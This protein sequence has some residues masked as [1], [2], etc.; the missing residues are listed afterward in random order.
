[1]L[2]VDFWFP[3]APPT[4]PTAPCLSWVDRGQESSSAVKGG[5]GG[6]EEGGCGGEARSLPHCAHISQ[7]L[8][9]CPSVKPHRGCLTKNLRGRGLW[10]GVG[11]MSAREGPCCLCSLHPLKGGF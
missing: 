2:G 6:G 11:R 1:M 8:P 3:Y 5:G 10:R 7:N 4:P 9:G